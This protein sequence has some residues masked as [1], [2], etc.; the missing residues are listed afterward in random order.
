MLLFWVYWLEEKGNQL[1]QLPP[2][3][4]LNVN[5]DR[6]HRLLESVVINMIT[7]YESV[8]NYGIYIFKLKHFPA[9]CRAKTQK[10][11]FTLKRLI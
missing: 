1:K 5:P 2:N 8:W 11:Y 3:G 10:V 4:V 9:L 6:V 7:F